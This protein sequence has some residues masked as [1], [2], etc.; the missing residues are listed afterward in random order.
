[1]K[2]SDLDR[3]LIPEDIRVKVKAEFD[4][5]MSD[6]WDKVDSCPGGQECPDHGSKHVGWALELEKQAE[7]DVR[8]W[9]FRLAMKREGQ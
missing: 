1:M 3:R 4:R 6:I 9:A 7:E 5:V 8:S 2:W